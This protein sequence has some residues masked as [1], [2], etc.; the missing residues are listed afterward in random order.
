MRFR[1]AKPFINGKVLDF[2]CGIGDAC[3]FC[4]EENYLGFDTDKEVLAIGAKRFPKANFKPIEE[5]K[6]VTPNSIDTILALAVIEHISSTPA[7]LQQIYPLLKNDGTV[8]ITTPNPAYDWIHGLG[9][10]IGIF[11]K[12]SHNEHINLTNKKKL[13]TD[14]QNTGFTLNKSRK[15]LLGANQLFILKKV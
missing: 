5:V 12:E 1:I 8:V 15:F 3:E 11:A 2:G 14:I 4:P 10:K 6:N 7:F 13:L 9:G